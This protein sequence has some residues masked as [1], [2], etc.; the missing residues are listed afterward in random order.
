M[1]IQER[2]AS[3]PAAILVD[4]DGLGATR[5]AIVSPGERGYQPVYSPL[6]FAELNE[7]MLKVRGCRDATFAE[8]EAAIVG[9]MFGWDCPGADPA[10]YDVGGRGGWLKGRAA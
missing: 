9:S 2:I 4:L 8:R 6:G 3:F 10:A 5:F 7:I 1:T